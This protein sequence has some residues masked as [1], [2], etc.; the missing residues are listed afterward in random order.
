MVGGLG[1][2]IE[3]TQIIV[4]VKVSRRRFLMGLERQ[5]FLLADVGG[6]EGKW[7]L[8]DLFPSR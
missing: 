6:G 7:T 2:R 8:V 4:G 3:V 5:S 1:V